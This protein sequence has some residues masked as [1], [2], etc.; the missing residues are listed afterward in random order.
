MVTYYPP[1]ITS[2]KWV[3]V[4][5]VFGEIIDLLML[6]VGS[7]KYFSGLHCVSRK[8]KRRN[9]RLFWRNSA[10]WCW[11]YGLGPTLST[12]AINTHS[13]CFTPSLFFSYGIRR[14]K[15]CRSRL[16]GWNSKMR[17][18]QINWK[19]S[20][21]AL[22]AAS[23]GAGWHPWVVVTQLLCATAHSTL[24]CE[25]IWQGV[26]RDSADIKDCDFHPYN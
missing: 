6:A 19:K 5:A 21:K 9:S 23:N 12:A 16:E 10:C 20:P 22:L 4:S 1:S 8:S 7:E 18:R 13:A 3:W 24:S 26:H 2:N 11:A 17:Q 15:G 25:L 14:K